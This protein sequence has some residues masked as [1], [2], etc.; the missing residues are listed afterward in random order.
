M[1]KAYK[2]KMFWRNLRWTLSL[3]RIFGKLLLG[4]N[5]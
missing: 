4:R 5:W 1:Y 3:R 2:K